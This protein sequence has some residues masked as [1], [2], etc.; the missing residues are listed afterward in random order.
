ML[1]SL[2]TFF[3]LPAE[4]P[5]VIRQ[6]GG[7]DALS[8]KQLNLIDDALI[9]VRLT[10][11]TTDTLS[12]P[13]VY[14]AMV[15]DRVVAFSALRCH[16]RHAWHAFLAQLGVIALHRAGRTAPPDA[17][18]EWRVLLRGLTPAFPGDEPWHLIVERPDW[19]AFLQCPAPAGLE[20]YSGCKTT[21]DDLDVLVTSK[22]HERKASIAMRN[23]P[24]DWFFA[25]LDLQT[26]AGFQGVGNYG[27]VRMNGGFSAR[28][29]LGFTP[30]DGGPGA[31]LLH[32][33]R[34]MLAAR[35]AL[36]DR[37]PFEPDNGLALLWTEPWDGTIALEVERLDPYFV[38][39]C[40]RVRLQRAGGRTVAR[41][42]HSACPRIAKALNGD[43]GDFWTAVRTKDHK[44]LSVS[45][46]GFPYDRLITMLLVNK[47]FAPSPA[48]LVNP[49]A[50]RRWRLVARGVAG[51]QGKTEGYHE[52]T[53]IVLSAET[54]AAF[55]GGEGRGALAA[56]AEAQMEEVADVRAA[57]SFAVA[58]VAAGGR[59][60]TADALTEEDRSHAVPYAR[61]LDAV[62]DRWFFGALDARFQ[63]L[64]TDAPAAAAACRR[65]FA[66]NLID[67]AVRLFTEAAA[68]VPCPAILRQR[69][70]VQA[71]GA[72]WGALR[73]SDG[74]FV[75]QTDIL[76]PA[77]YR[78][79]RGAGAG[80]S[81]VPD[82]DVAG[83]AHD[84]AGVEPA[85][86]AALRRQPLADVSTAVLVRTLMGRYLSG[87]VG[88][89]VAAQL[90]QVI[91]ILTPKDRPPRTAH[92]PESSM[93]AALRTGG[94]SGLRLA[95]ILS[96]PPARR[97]TL[98]VH[99]CRRLASVT[100]GPFDLRL[101]ARFLLAGDKAADHQIL[102]EYLRAEF[103]ATT[104]SQKELSAHD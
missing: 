27:I 85:T 44:V 45:R 104:S 98:M 89:D 17:T 100:P 49:T 72:F 93:G 58:I 86:L 50:S 55:L 21:P 56:L 53:D 77:R 46:G 22:N 35:D 96:A 39:I 76:A 10:D 37:Y 80:G 78:D 91:A 9:R 61:R 2:P 3:Q 51:G 6:H 30:A 95:R 38:E 103:A 13:A 1:L 32:D 7:V 43:V 41:I 59:A 79:A 11:G 29:C 88:I 83:L 16:Q 48:M 73:R 57:L 92:D 94:V 81:R 101:L 54:V 65:A 20:E 12:L 42:A 69:V 97:S 36:L 28:P 74:R 23:A 84:V 71:W 102:Q 47:A 24:D 63:A 68:V 67:A 90:V 15:M 75:G 40:R 60:P 87:A 70:R 62:S 33:M 99:A 64:E 34:G 14:A 4:H 19:P 31:H 25:L 26:M 8:P 66:S 52:R 5:H 18:S 82:C